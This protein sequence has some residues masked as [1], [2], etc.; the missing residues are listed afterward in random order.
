MEVRRALDG[1]WYALESFRTY[2]NDD[3]MRVWED[4][5]LVVAGCPATSYMESIGNERDGAGSD[6]NAS[7]EASVVTEASITTD[8]IEVRRARDGEW[9]TLKDFEACYGVRY[10]R[11]IWQDCQAVVR[12]AVVSSYMEGTGNASGWDWEDGGASEH[13]D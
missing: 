1:S 6:G 12:G 2:Y 7:M 8:A 11:I 4:C 10:G 13:V 3:A 9:Y 5:Q